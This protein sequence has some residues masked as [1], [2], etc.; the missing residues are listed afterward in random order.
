M[1]HS[2]LDAALLVS[3]LDELQELG[4]T[5][6]ASLFSGNRPVS[7]VE[8][9][10]N[11]LDIDDRETA[12]QRHQFAE[13]ERAFPFEAPAPKTGFERQLWASA[14]APRR[15]DR[16]VD[17]AVALWRRFVLRE[18]ARPGGA[19]GDVFANAIVRMAFSSPTVVADSLKMLHQALRDRVLMH[20]D[21]PPNDP[22]APE[23][24]LAVV[25]AA[26]C[27]A[28]LSARAWGR[29]T[30]I[31]KELLGGKEWAGFWDLWVLEH[32]ALT[33]NRRVWAGV[34]DLSMDADSAVDHAA[35]KPGWRAAMPGY[36]AHLMVR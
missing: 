21:G 4:L 23:T 16:A 19:S 1:T 10:R 29:L 33:L 9:L 2:D 20:P 34:P 36:A 7:S 27:P 5:A 11:F 28:G 18:R 22:L 31:S 30:A 3:A 13:M 26:G 12:V 32:A 35:M 25:I 15:R 14:I 8:A 24:V 17:G 6:M